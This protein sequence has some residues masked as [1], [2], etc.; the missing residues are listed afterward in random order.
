MHAFGL[1]GLFLRFG[2]PSAERI[3]D[4]E[5]DSGRGGGRIAHSDHHPKSTEQDV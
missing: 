3:G 1:N 4:I 2:D 5:H